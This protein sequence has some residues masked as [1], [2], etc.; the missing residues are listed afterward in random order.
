MD[1]CQNC[2]VISLDVENVKFNW[3]SFFIW[4]PFE[5]GHSSYCI[6]SLLQD[7]RIQISR[8]KWMIF[9]FVYIN[10]L[11]VLYIAGR[12]LWYIIAFFVC[13]HRTFD[14]RMSKNDTWYKSKD[15][16]NVWNQHPML[17]VNHHRYLRNWLN[18]LISHWQC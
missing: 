7:C 9:H 17:N 8:N 3:F 16:N 2:C 13:F 5:I 12:I 18:W 4:F 6:L 1:F 10:L 11:I 15:T 14:F